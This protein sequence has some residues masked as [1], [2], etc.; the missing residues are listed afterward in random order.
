MNERFPRVSGLRDAGLEPLYRAA[1]AVAAVAGAI[2]LFIEPLLGL[3]LAF[4]VSLTPDQVDAVADLV[5]ALAGLGAPLAV[6]AAVRPVVSAPKTVDDIMFGPD[7]VPARADI[8]NDLK[9]VSEDAD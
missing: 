6:A 3:L 4:G 8:E 1:I 2:M 7:G 5:R 9:E